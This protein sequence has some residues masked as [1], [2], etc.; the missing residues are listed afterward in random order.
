MAF[1]ESIDNGRRNIPP[2]RETNNYNVISSNIMQLF[3]G[4][5][6]TNIDFV[7]LS[8]EYEIMGLFNKLNEPGQQ[9]AIERVEELTEIPKY[10]K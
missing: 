5:V 2:D 6:Q 4:S 8:K 1:K 10:Q 7:K 9:K 3:M